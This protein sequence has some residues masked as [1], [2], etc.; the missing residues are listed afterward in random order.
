MKLPIANYQHT[1]KHAY[2]AFE[3]FITSYPSPSQDGTLVLTATAPYSNTCP[4]GIIVD[5]LDPDKKIFYR[6]N[7]IMGDSVGGYMD[8]WTGSDESDPYSLGTK[9]GNVLV[10]SD[11]SYDINGV[12]FGQPVDLGSSNV[13]MYYVG[14]DSSYVYRIC[15]AESTDGGRTFTKYGAVLSPNL[16]DEFGCTGPGIFIEGGTWYMSY[17]VWGGPV[18]SSPNHDPGVSSGCRLATSTDGITWTKTGTYIVPLAAPYAR[19]EDGQFY[20][21]GSKYVFIHSAALNSPPTYPWGSYIVSS[22]TLNATFIREKILLFN[23]NQPSAVQF[24]YFC[25]DGF[26]YS[27]YQKEEFGG[28]GVN[29]IYVI[30]LIPP[31]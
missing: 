27:Y 5:P 6:S 3:K 17:T 1:Y 10:G 18:N 19:V 23:Y 7:F 13:R 22:D 9:Y 29:N 15:R 31:V 26:I 4:S 25:S 24:L 28:G 16:T 14:I 12:R 20:K 2:S 21:F 30:K 8:L 11:A